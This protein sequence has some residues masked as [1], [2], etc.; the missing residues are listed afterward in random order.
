MVLAVVRGLCERRVPT[1]LEELVDFET[2]V[3]AGFVLAGVLAGLVDGTVGS[4]IGHLEQT[5][6]WWGRDSSRR[7]TAFEGV[8][9]WCSSSGAAATGGCAVGSTP[10]AKPAEKRFVVYEDAVGPVGKL[11]RMA[12]AVLLLAIGRISR[13]NRTHV[14][15][16]P[17]FLASARF[18]P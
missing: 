13:H 12:L 7:T 15:D 1:G 8:D 4:D 9:K 2:V 11:A 5:R 17:V 6:T 3:L 16:T 14:R 18:S 10:W